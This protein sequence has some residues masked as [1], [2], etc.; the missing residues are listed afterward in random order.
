MEVSR[1]SVGSVAETSEFYRSVLARRLRCILHGKYF[2]SLMLVA[3]F[4]ALFAP[5][6]CVIIGQR[7]DLEL[8]ML[9]SMAMVL[10]IIELV[11]LCTVEPIYFLSFFFVMDLLG[12]M[13]MVFDISFLLGTGARFPRCMV[14]L[15]LKGGRTEAALVVPALVRA[16]RSARIGIRAGRLSRAVRSF[17]LFCPSCTRRQNKDGGVAVLIT[18]QLSHSV[19]TRVSKLTV[20]LAMAMPLFDI[21]AFTRTDY[22]MQT[23]VSRLSEM[24]ERKKMHIF[25]KE[26][27]EMVDFFSLRNYGPYEACS[28]S[29]SESGFFICE[30]IAGSFK[31]KVS[32][33]QRLSSALLVH[34]DTFMVSFN[35]HGPAKL[36][37]GITIFSICIIIFIMVLS[38]FAL[39]N[40]VAQ[41]AV[42][43]LERMLVTVREIATTV[44]K[45]NQDVTNSD[46]DIVDMDAATEMELLERVVQKLAIITDLQTRNALEHTEGMQDED[47]GILNMMRGKSIVAEARKSRASGNLAASETLKR[48]KT[49]GPTGIQLED[50]GMTQELYQ[51][52]AFNSL[53]LTKSQ[54][55]S[56]AIFTISRFHDAGEGFVR[57]EDEEQTL[58]RFVQ[59]V[60]KDRAIGRR[61]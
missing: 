59:A 53:P 1:S 31:P 13:S 61:F 56:L 51:S 21:L 28:G 41:L 26:L 15:T 58:Q 12:T 14:P 55:V 57:T 6:M 29:T 49:W 18:D 38:G 46:I 8:D 34:T 36:E 27:G 33:P 39:S 25:N 3:L 19:A 16:A 30:E 50:F 45:V 23:W 10:F 48:K 5:D 24:H 44:F 35:M 20:L 22:S 60:E 54:K 32:A 4:V 2:S 7:S 11:L 9:M 43:P 17:R 42:Q 47:I 37:S 52:W 40:V